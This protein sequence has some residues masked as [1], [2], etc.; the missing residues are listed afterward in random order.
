ML[1]RKY[2]IVYETNERGQ[3]AYGDT[4]T[5]EATGT[6]PYTAVASVCKDEGPDA[7]GQDDVVLAE[8]IDERGVPVAMREIFRR[9]VETYPQP[10]IVGLRGH[11]VADEERAQELVYTNVV[12]PHYYELVSESAATGQI[13]LGEDRQLVL[14]EH[15]TELK[16]ALSHHWGCTI[17]ES[18]VKRKQSV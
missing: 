8:E 3:K 1:Q 17:P 18:K 14:R 4:N 16:D 12:V 6:N 5:V 15:R 10:Y 11:L 9:V 7:W 13:F 2:R